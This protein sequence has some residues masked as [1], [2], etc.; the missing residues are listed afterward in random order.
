[1]KVNIS[2]STTLV[3]GHIHNSKISA[4]VFNRKQ[5]AAIVIPSILLATMYPVFQ[6]LAG[7]LENDQIA[8]YLGLAVYWLIW[9]SIFPLLMIGFQ[10]IKEL[11]L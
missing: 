9:G 10:N 11:V 4:L 7:S 5:I 2:F 6:F 1:M 3:W 8:W